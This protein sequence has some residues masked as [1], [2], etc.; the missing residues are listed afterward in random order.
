MGALEVEPQLDVV[1]GYQEVTTGAGGD[2][3]Q[4]ASHGTP[5]GDAPWNE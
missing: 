1:F 4:V 2:I 5:D 3:Q